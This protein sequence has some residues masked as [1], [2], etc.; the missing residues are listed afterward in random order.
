MS[1]S[2]RIKNNANQLFDDLSRGYPAL[3]VLSK[4]YKYYPLPGKRID[5]IIILYS[6]EKRNDEHGRHWNDANNS[7][8]NDIISYYKPYFGY[9]GTVL[10]K[11]LNQA[12]NMTGFAYLRTGR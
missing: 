2:S 6:Y 9:T 10:R 5:H 8:N 3:A 4:N 12:F 7:R 1:A 11:E